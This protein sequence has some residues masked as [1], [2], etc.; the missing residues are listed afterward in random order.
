MALPTLRFAR[1]GLVLVAL[2][3]LSMTFAY[4][5]GRIIFLAAP[6]F[7]VAGGW[8]L[9]D[10]R[11]LA[12]ATVVALLALDLGYAI[13]MQAYGVQHGIDTSVSHRVPVY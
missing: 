3:A 13:Y 12:V 2:C 10:R 8:A 5:W 11:R 6:V 7:Y 4:D 1:R 9:R